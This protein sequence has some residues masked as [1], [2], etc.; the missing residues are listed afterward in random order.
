M[1]KKPHAP[2]MKKRY[3]GDH[4]NVDAVQTSQRASDQVEKAPSSYLLL[5]ES[6]EGGDHP[7]KREADRRHHAPV[8]EP[9]LDRGVVREN[10]PEVKPEPRREHSRHAGQNALRVEASVAPPRAAG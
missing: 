3:D 9:G 8:L 4:C 5:V 1:S 6:P 7:A 2:A 10:Q